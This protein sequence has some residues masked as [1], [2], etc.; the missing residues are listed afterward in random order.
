M[1][2]SEKGEVSDVRTDSP[3]WSAGLVP[4]MTILAVNGQEYSPDVLD[5]RAA[6]RATF[7]RADFADRQ[8]DGWYPNALD[9]T[10]TTAF[11]TRTSSALRARPTCSRPSPPPTQNRRCHP[12]PMSS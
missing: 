1:N 10:I 11:D 12:E 2:I 7:H 4:D 5:V 3:A 6:R 9:S 8:A